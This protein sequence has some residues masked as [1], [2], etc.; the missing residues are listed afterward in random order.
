MFSLS[1]N[2]LFLVCGTILHGQKKKSDTRSLS[3][4]LYILGKPNEYDSTNIVRD[5]DSYLPELPALKNSPGKQ[6][7]NEI[8][9]TQMHASELRN[10]Q[11]CC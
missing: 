5:R 6:D 8:D 1:M 9:Q 10:I 7:N 2:G 11:C 3:F 4:W